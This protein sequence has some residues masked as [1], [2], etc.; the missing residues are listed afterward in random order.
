MGHHMSKEMLRFFAVFNAVALVRNVPLFYV[1]CERAQARMHTRHN[2][3][4]DTHTCAHTR[5]I[6]EKQIIHQAGHSLHADPNQSTTCMVRMGA[7]LA[8]ASVKDG[9]ARSC[10]NTLRQPSG[11]CM[12]QLVMVKLRG[13]V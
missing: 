3:C 1:Q 12:L 8:A 13:R 6:E 5:V 9:Q 4:A 10:D 7:A 2:G 11:C